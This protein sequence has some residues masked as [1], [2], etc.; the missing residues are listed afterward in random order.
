MYISP[1]ISSHR[2]FDVS[3]YQFLQRLIF[4]FTGGAIDVNRKWL[5]PGIEL[6]KIK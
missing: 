1:V 3:A 6:I 4:L 5:R 2:D